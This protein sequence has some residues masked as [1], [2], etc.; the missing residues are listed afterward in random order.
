[1]NDNEQ[2]QMHK[3]PASILA[4]LSHTIVFDG[5]R[6][7]CGHNNIPKENT[8]VAT[9]GRRLTLSFDSICVCTSGH[10]P[11]HHHSRNS[12]SKYDIKYNNA[13][14]VNNKIIKTNRA[15]LNSKF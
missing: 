10:I 8:E 9:A 2:D 12:I 14:I 13:D 6:E 15:F 5:Q 7:R 11:A 4:H 1:M 3:T